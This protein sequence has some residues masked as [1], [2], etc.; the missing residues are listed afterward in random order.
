MLCNATGRDSFSIMPALKRP[1]AA[2]GGRAAKAARKTDVTQVLKGIAAAEVP[3][4]SKA[5]L[6]DMIGVSLG[7]YK[8]TRDKYQ[9][10]VV[11]MVEGVLTSVE[12]ALQTE[13]AE[14]EKF[15]VEDGQ[16]KEELDGKVAAKGEEITTKHSE[17]L[18][19]KQEMAAVAEAFRDAR[20]AVGKAEVNGVTVEKEAGVKSTQK[21]TLLTLKAGLQAATEATVADLVKRLTKIGVSET[22]MVA[23]PAVLSKPE[24]E[25]G[26]FDA[27]VITSISEDLDKRIADT[28]Q[29]LQNVE[30]SKAAAAEALNKAKATLSEA[31]DK[32]VS[33]AGAYTKAKGE[34][35]ALETEAGELQGA[36]KK[37]KET[38]RKHVAAS[39]KAKGKLEAFQSGPKH[40]F[41][42]LRDAIEAV[43]E[44]PEAP[45]DGAAPETAGDDPVI[46]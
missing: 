23:L 10:K 7:A 6:S 15:I 32:Q 21:E 36:V 25:R 27:M 22:M 13:V 41:E 5:L 4:V 12:A 40:E 29:H 16:A 44:A 34:E 20:E 43:P 3:A 19:K 37:L 35:D 33:A 46:A 30:P 8:E 28:E 14:A 39:S 17:V 31:S 24:A 1:A 42:T 26:S 2:A 18:A 45:A 38:S 11:E 9:N